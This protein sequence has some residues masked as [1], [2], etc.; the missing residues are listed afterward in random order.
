M[1]NVIFGT[2]I[3]SLRTARVYYVG[4]STIYEGMPVCYQFDTT[5]NVLG[6]SKS[7]GGEDARNQT[8]KNTTAEGYLNEGKFLRVEDPFTD[9]LQWF[10]GVVRMGG[11]CGKVGP[12]WLDVYEPNGAIVPV[13]AGV[14]CTVGRTILC[15]NPS[16]SYLGNPVNST[17]GRPVA[18]ALETNAA[19]DTTPGLILAKLCPNE[20][21]NQ[22]C[23][24]S[25]M[26]IGNGVST[27]VALCANT[28][29]VAS[30][31][32]DG[33]FTAFK[34]IGEIAGA[35]GSCGNGAVQMKC[36]VNSTS[37]GTPPT[38][39]AAGGVSTMMQFLTGAVATGIFY[40]G[41]FCTLNQDSTPATVSSAY[42][43]NIMSSFSTNTNAPAEL[44]HFRFEA[45]GSAKPGYFW[46]AKSNDAVCYAAASSISNVGTLKI[47]IGGVDKYIVLSSAA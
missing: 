23:N 27:E 28:I 17:R 14:E 11:Y 40:A 7:E 30:T 35:G 34:V 6:Y 32:T 4:T 2:N 9:N 18:V 16:L 15:V 21:V 44:A 47:K 26:L 8:D 20:F 31:Q 19:L 24:S 12:K 3:D 36:L 13:R 22:L 1:A 25:A 42:I 29:N 10:A 5:T 33:D 38:M 46:V 37:Q 43:Y 41:R 39:Y 45:D